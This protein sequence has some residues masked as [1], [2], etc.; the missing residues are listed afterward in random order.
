MTKDLRFLKYFKLMNLNILDMFWTIADPLSNTRA[1]FF[2]R[3]RLRL[4]QAVS[5]VHFD[6]ALEAFGCRLAF[7]QVQLVLAL[8]FICLLA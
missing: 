6:V 5:H 1:P 4:L 2:D 3:P 7:S 8:L